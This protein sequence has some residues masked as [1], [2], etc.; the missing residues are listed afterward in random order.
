MNLD[1]KFAPVRDAIYDMVG[2]FFKLIA[3][4]FNYPQNLGMPTVYNIPNKRYASLPKH[5]TFFPP[6][7]Q[8]HSWVEVIFGP[9]PTMS[10]VERHMYE[11]PQEGF[12]NFYIENYRNLYFL[13]NWLSEF[14]Q[15]QFNQCLDI[16]LLETTREVLFIGIFIYYQIV[17][18][19]LNLS[20]VLYINPYTTPWCYIT[21]LVDWTEEVLSGILPTIIGV[22]I[23]GTL[24]LGFLGIIGDA[25]NH[26]VFTMPF[27]PR[28]GE[29]TTILINGQMK[30]VLVFHYLPQLWY[31]YSIPNEIREFWYNERPEILEY[32]QQAY[33]NFDIQ[34]LPNQIIEKLN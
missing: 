20:W 9:N 17:V 12:Y 6:F 5:E 15:I 3:G 34:F 10:S 13:P 23:S 31:K 21:V 7:Q 27:L 1:D 25:L 2:N 22:N 18:I 26:L 11:N 19:R 30:N 14:V 8:P 33:N 4:F 32:M 16:S 28:E 24:F 29:A